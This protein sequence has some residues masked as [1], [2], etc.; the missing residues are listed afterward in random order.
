[1]FD[2]RSA[3]RAR[4][5]LQLAI[6]TLMERVQSLRV[7]SLCPFCQSEPALFLLLPDHGMIGTNLICCRNKKCRQELLTLRPGQ[8][9]AI[10][11]FLLLISS[12]NINKKD[13][14]TVVQIFKQTHKKSLPELF[15]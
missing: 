4:N 6:E 9:H 14:K 2:R 7:N 8:L 5:H 1:M 15:A 3:V 12:R 10:K 11:D 13:A